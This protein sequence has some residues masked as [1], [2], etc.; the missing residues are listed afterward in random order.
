MIYTLT[1]AS[2]GG[3]NLT[4]ITVYGGWGDAGRDQQAYTVYYSKVTAPTTFIQL[5]T[6]NY[7]PSNPANVQSATRATLTPA[8]GWLATNVAAVKFDFTN[9]GSENGYCGYSAIDI[10]GIGITIQYTATPTNGFA[11]LTVQFN[12]P[13]VD[14]GGNAITRW[15]WNFGDGDTSTNQNPSHIYNTVGSYS[16]SLVATNNLGH[17]VTGSGPSI[18]VG[19]NSGLVTNGGFETGDFTGWTLSG[20]TS[21]W[22]V[23][24]NGTESGIPPH[25]GACLAAL[26][27]TSAE[28]FISQTLVTTP[29]TSYLV[30]CWLNH[31]GG[32]PGDIF[33][34]SWN[35]TI[36][37]DETN[38]AAPVWTNY[39][40]VVPAT[41]T[42][43]VLQFGFEASGTDWLGLD[44]ISVVAVPGII[45][46]SLSGGN[47]VINGSNGVSGQT[48]YVLTTTN[49]A[50]P[51][52]QWMPVATNVLNA[53]GNFS[54]TATNAVNPNVPQ[55]FY[56]LQ[57]Q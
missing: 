20:D 35:G 6:V 47:L 10:Y 18:S 25:S 8:S 28:G 38:P 21:P 54:I 19:F 37:L 55:Q 49:L 36:L 39:Q 30:S 45:G 32:D 4:N 31:S 43:T 27:T 50:L 44:D 17:M 26:G 16:P 56:I 15:N 29:G 40:F 46:I 57:L 24:D 23:V 51:R 11:P 5:D 12:C 1:N 42:S 9:P 22:T 41:G 13:G 2:G 14:S 3:Y 53:G 48:C 34:V 52:S 7:N 33:M